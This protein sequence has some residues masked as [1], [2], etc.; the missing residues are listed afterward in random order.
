MILRGEDKLFHS[1]PYTLSSFSLSFS[2][3]FLLL[4][5][6]SLLYNIKE[7]RSYWRFLGIWLKRS[8]VWQG[9]YADRRCVWQMF[10]SAGD[11]GSFCIYQKYKLRSDWA[12]SSWVADLEPQDRNLPGFLS[13]TALKCKLVHI[14]F[15]YL[16]EC[17]HT[18]ILPSTLHPLTPSPPSILEFSFL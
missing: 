5:L 17:V 13:A 15:V 12:P 11:L 7:W 8:G 3:I 18:Y 6:L 2:S 1:P 9:D 16:C 10:S 14:D 4:I